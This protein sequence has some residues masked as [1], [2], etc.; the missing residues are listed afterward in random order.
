MDS[1]QEKIYNEIIT[2]LLNVLENDD[3]IPHN[4]VKKIYSC[5]ISALM[6]E[7]LDSIQKIERLLKNCSEYLLQKLWFNIFKKYQFHQISVIFQSEISTRNFVRN[8]WCQEVFNNSFQLDDTEP[9]PSSS[10]L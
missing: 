7:K 6:N 8:L 10:A 1:R 4:E 9:V 2:F 3:S 5:I